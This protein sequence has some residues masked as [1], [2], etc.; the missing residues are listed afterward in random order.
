MVI[1]KDV[2][3]PSFINKTLERVNNF[4]GFDLQIYKDHNHDIHINQS[5]D[6]GIFLD[7]LI[8]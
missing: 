7:N 1:K 3:I 4:E 6:A 5:I 2:I 8:K